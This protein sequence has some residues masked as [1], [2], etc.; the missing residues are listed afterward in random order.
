MSSY[1][2]Y[3]EEYAKRTVR[4]QTRDIEDLRS[5]GLQELAKYRGGEI[6]EDP[7]TCPV[8]IE[9]QKLIDAAMPEAQKEYDE[10]S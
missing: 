9:F 4:N 10:E 7:K 1:E 2:T 8:C 3:A 5:D 6:G